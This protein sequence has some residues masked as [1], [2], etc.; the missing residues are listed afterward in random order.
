MDFGLVALSG[1]I[2][3]SSPLLLWNEKLNFKK[4]Q[5]HNPH[6]FDIEIISVE[7]VGSHGEQWV[8]DQTLHAPN[9]AAVVISVVGAGYNV[10]PARE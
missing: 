2:A 6:L 3:R 9:D 10:A 8:D 4:G 7:P 5:C 1:S